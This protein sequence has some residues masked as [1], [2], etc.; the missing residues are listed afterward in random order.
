MNDAMHYG[1]GPHMQ[2]SRPDNFQTGIA[3]VRRGLI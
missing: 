1:E 3:S 2:V